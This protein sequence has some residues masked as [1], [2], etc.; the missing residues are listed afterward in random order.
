MVRTIKGLPPVV[1]PPKRYTRCRP[2]GER[3]RSRSRLDTLSGWPGGVT[4]AK[5]D[6]RSGATGAGRISAQAAN[7]AIAAPPASPAIAARATRRAGVAASARIVC[8]RRCERVVDLQRAPA[9]ESSRPAAIFFQAPSQ[10]SANGHGRAGRQPR[11]VGVLR[12]HVREGG[13]EILTG[14]R[15]LPGQHF[16]EHRAERPEVGP[17]VDWTS[18]G[19]LGTHV[20]GGPEEDVV[21]R[22][23]RIGRRRVHRIHRRAG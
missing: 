22:R 23:Q 18:P 2:S 15:L 1:V 14:E 20:R 19:L 3:A 5:R 10:K 6:G 11:P 7:A 21:L 12:Q 16:V 8:G 17:H 4:I 9:A 13:G